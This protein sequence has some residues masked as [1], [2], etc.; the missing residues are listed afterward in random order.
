MLPSMRSRA[1]CAVRRR[2]TAIQRYSHVEA[3]WLV[4]VGPGSVAYRQSTYIVRCD[5]GPPRRI[6]ASG[7]QQGVR[8]HLLVLER[9]SLPLAQFGAAMSCYRI[10]L[11]LFTANASRPE[12]AAA[13]R[14]V[15]GAK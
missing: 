10:A 4:D 9:S 1:P 11:G 3:V 8:S 7:E 12:Q 6:L 2:D 13:L 14:N 15:G 5:S